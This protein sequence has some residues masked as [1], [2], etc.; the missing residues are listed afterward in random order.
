M[1][2]Q[3]PGYRKN[4][5][6]ILSLFLVLFPW[7]TYFKILLYSDMQSQVLA[8]VDGMA[9]DVYFYYKQ[10][11]LIIMAAFTV[12]FFLGERVFPDKKDNNV[13]LLKGN[14]KVLFILSVVFMLSALI[15][16]IFA[17]DSKTAW[18]GLP[19]EGEGFF[20]LLS[21][22]VIMLMFYNYFGN[23]YGLKL[24]KKCILVLS[25][26]TVV[27]GA[28]EY[29]Y[30][31]LMMT[32]VVKW[33]VGMGDYK[34]SIAG[35]EVDIFTDSVALSFG[36]PNY[37]GGFVCLLFPFVLADFY[38]T[39]Q[40]KSTIISGVLSLGLSFCVMASGATTSLYV[41]IFE[42]VLVSLIYGLKKRERVVY[43]KIGVIIIAITALMVIFGGR[44]A[45]VFSNEN[46]AT[47]KT[48]ESVFEIDDITLADNRV[49]LK[50]RDAELTITYDE[51]EISF[52]DAEGKKLDAMVNE[53]VFSFEDKSLENIS[54]KLLVTEE[55]TEDILAKLVVDAGYDDSIDF[56]ILENG[57]ISG[58][59]Q[60]NS[61]VMDIEDAGTSESLK[62]YYG[63]FTGRGYAWVNSWPVL[64]ESIL[65]GKGPGHFVYEFKQ[66][67]YV[68][69][70]Q[71][72]KSTKY[73]I[74]KPHSMYLQYAINIGLIGMVAFV[75]IFVLALVRGGK[76]LKKSKRV[77]AEVI[78]GVVAICGFL[79]Y[80]AVND[81]VLSVTPAVMAVVGVMLAADRK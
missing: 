69:M 66:N 13:S 26:I 41:A 7:I 44:V 11:A 42:F 51:G 32:N 1:K 6:R 31:P 71:T 45:E 70:L 57:K 76:V 18:W 29:F 46:S 21:Y 72:H 60:N 56:Y 28:I 68:G 54:V 48:E 47:G 34:E 40:K 35:N 38:E 50:G 77:S 67:D 10:V 53:N 52:K 64:K 4:I 49:K 39:A 16:A 15:S 65:I 27:L 73:V 37:F 43:I 19:T 78:A 61:I 30:K 23:D 3:L 25:G 33:L 59:G 81:S 14:N 5:I 80:S 58:V 17:Q 74:D 55:G 8:N 2:A 20:T 22:I 75:G 12:L 24:F 79:I 63:M 62:K 9:T 36:N